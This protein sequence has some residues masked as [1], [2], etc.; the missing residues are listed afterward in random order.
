MKER[1]LTGILPKGGKLGDF[2]L[3]NGGN[4]KSHLVTLF[5][6][7]ISYPVKLHTYPLDLITYPL[8]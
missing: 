1:N 5:L 6:S 7:L 8:G 3:P 2:S 4:R